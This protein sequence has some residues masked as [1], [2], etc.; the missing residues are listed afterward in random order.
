MRASLAA[1][2]GFLLAGSAVEYAEPGQRVNLSGASWQSV[3]RGLAKGGSRVPMTAI[4]RPVYRHAELVR[5]LH[6]ASI[7]V[8]GASTRAGSFGERV[9]LNLAEYDGR[10]YPVNAR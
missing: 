4:P 2:A 3:R 5:L 10:I 6:P 8:I 9:L 7:A 1:L